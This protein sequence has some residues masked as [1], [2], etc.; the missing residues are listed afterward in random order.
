M[1]YSAEEIDNE[2]ANSLASIKDSL[3]SEERYRSVMTSYIEQTESDMNK[4]WGSI[5]KLDRA[6][7][8]SRCHKIKGGIQILNEKEILKNCLAIEDLWSCGSKAL[9]LNVHHE[10][11]TNWGR[12][13]K[14]LVSETNEHP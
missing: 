7:I 10:M 8:R 13:K 2:L 5:S 6:S 3:A 12:T 11:V 9:L 14:I 4:L 1:I